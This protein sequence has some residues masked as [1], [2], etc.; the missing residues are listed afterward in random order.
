MT[1]PANVSHWSRRL[2]LT[3]A[4]FL[5]IWN[6]ALIV[7][8]GRQTGI[9]LGLFGFV[10]HTI[11]GKAYALIPTY[12]DRTLSTDRLLAPQ[13][14]LTTTGTIALAVGT[15]LVHPALLTTGG[16]L[17]L[18][19]TAVFLGTLIWTLRGNFSGRETSTGTHNEHRVVVDRIANAGTPV[20]LLFLGLGSAGVALSQLAIGGS[21]V[22]YTPRWIHL[23]AVGG[24]T[25]L[26]FSL[27]FRLLPRF[28]ATT[29]PEWLVWAVIPAGIFGPLLLAAGIPDGPLFL[30]GALVQSIAMVGY[31]ALVL[32][33]LIR[34]ERSRIGYS[35]IGAGAVSALIVVSLGLHFAFV[36]QTGQQVM[37]HYRV[38]L[39]G[40]LGL[41]IVGISY[42]FYPPAVFDTTVPT[43]ALF[44]LEGPFTGDRIGRLVIGFL[45]LAVLLDL[46]ENSRRKPRPSGA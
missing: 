39:L 43:N 38:A 37:A 1:T 35:A 7:G 3:G 24:A 21:F 44:G 19:G 6:F 46:T 33:L 5:V 30:I 41:T 22:A 20:A 26:I 9:F 12:F 8:I 14:F 25:V 11:F 40:F 36:G 42:Q 45:C 27:G 17:W 23:I 10:F 16:L 28:L 2:V 32:T 15:E 4:C 34:T 31:A 18:A 13:F 29:P